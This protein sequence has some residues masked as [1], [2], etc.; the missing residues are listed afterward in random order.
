MDPT[1][2]ASAETYRAELNEFLDANLPSD[3]QGIGAVPPAERAE[4]HERWRKTLREHNLLAANWPA[5]YGGGG[6]S[7]LELVILNEEFAKRGVPTAGSNDAFSISMVGNTILHW[8]TE[9]QK[10]HYIP[11]ILDGDDVWCQG[12]SEP[13]AGSDLANLGCRAE[14]DGDE[15]VVNGQKIW[16]SAGQSANMIFVLARTDPDVTKHAGISFLLM[17]MDQPGVEVRPITNIVGQDHFCEVFFTDARC[18]KDNVL[19]GVN[20]GWAVGNTLLGFERGVGATTLSLSFRA[21][22][23]Q[24]IEMA[25]ELGKTDDPLVR[26]DIARFHTMVEIMRIRGMQ[27]LTRFLNGQAPGPEAS[28]GK[29]FWSHY[30][31]DITESAMNLIGP[32]SVVHFGEETRGGLGPPA[33]GTAN[34]AAN[35]MASFMIARPGTIYAGTSQVQRNIIGE[36]VLGLPKEPRAD[37]GTWRETQSAKQ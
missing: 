7:H 4:F 23:D 11:R 6:L 34:T 24:Y 26:Q 19:G 3:W 21:H 9:E 22:L 32:E 2:P 16:T 20:N 29:L 36:R 30:L 31:H 33:I 12:Y 8:G 18:P 15:W 25:R 14:L 35:W 28:I 37:T 10:Q 5:E 17:S 1:Y 13:N 27:A